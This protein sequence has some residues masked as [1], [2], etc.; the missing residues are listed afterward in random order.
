[1]NPHKPSKDEQ[2]FVRV[3][4]FAAALGL[5]V[6]VAFLYSVK[7]VHPD[8]RLEFTFGTVVAFGVTAA[9]AVAF[10]NVLFKGEFA[11]G[12]S[13]P[14]QEPGRRRARRWLVF[15]LVGSALATASA[16]IYSLKDVSSANRREVF[17]G[18]AI[19]IVVL[20][21]GGFLIHRSV[22]FF[23]EQDRANLQHQREVEELEEQDSHEHPD[24]E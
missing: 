20:S 10:C 24:E 21:I 8:F 14:G 3:V 12:H 7:Q 22:R 23:E 16:F 18:T 17:L 19:A 5:G 13:I 2:D 9:L 1:M 11:A 6:M 15:F 4:K